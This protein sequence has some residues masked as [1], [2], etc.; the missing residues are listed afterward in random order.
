[1]RVGPL[2]HPLPRE[3]LVHQAVHFLV[4]KARPPTP[5]PRRRPA[6]ASAA[7]S[8]SSMLSCGRSAAPTGEFNDGIPGNEM[9]TQYALT[10]SAPRRDTAATA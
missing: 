9:F 1:V 8:I 3:R 5:Q 7:S 4:R 6:A 2:P 10:A